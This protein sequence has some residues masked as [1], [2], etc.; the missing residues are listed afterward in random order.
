VKKIHRNVER[1]CHAINDPTDYIFDDAQLTSPMPILFFSI[2]PS[3]L[4]SF[5]HREYLAKEL[6]V[7]WQKIYPWIIDTHKEE[8]MPY[9]GRNGYKRL[10]LWGIVRGFGVSDGLWRTVIIH[11]QLKIAKWF[12]SIGERLVP[13]MPEIAVQYGHLDIALWLYDLDPDNIYW[14]LASQD[15]AQYRHIYI[16]E[17]LLS[18]GYSLNENTFKAGIKSG[19]IDVMEWLYA[20]ECPCVIDDRF[21]CYQ[22][23][24]EIVKWLKERNMGWSPTS[25]HFAIEAGLIDLLAYLH[26]QGERFCPVCHVLAVC[27]YNTETLRWL[28]ENGCPWNKENS[29]Y[30][31]E[32]AR[33]EPTFCEW[34]R[35]K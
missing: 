7:M 14:S 2:L 25:F 13:S 28:I 15:A 12:I 32:S 11:G 1:G 21:A 6:N 16:L 9:C 17:W 4:L 10:R 33:I 29:L 20:H 27:N 35:T 18:I 26:E 22:G 31:L 19:S 34:L 23:N 5:F 8:F 24:V 30:V 3:D